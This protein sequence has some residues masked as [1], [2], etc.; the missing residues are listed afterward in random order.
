MGVRDSSTGVQDYNH[1]AALVC[2]ITVMVRS[3][4]EL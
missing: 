1:G 3:F 4:R 2:G